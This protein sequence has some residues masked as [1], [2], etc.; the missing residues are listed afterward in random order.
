MDIQLNGGI[1]EQSNGSQH[2]I[3]SALMHGK[4]L[5]LAGGAEKKKKLRR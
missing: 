5:C 4:E 1:T 3:M 2:A